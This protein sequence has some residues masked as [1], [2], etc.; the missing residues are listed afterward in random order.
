MDIEGANRTSDSVNV[1]ETQEL[2]NRITVCADIETAR[3]EFRNIIKD[4]LGASSKV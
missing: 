4:T 2:C 3:T 1:D